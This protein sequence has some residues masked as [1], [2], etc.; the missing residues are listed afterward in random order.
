MPVPTW[1][2]WDFSGRVFYRIQ[3]YNTMV[4]YHSSPINMFGLTKDD[5]I[6]LMSDASMHYN[7]S[8]LLLDT[9]ICYEKKITWYC[10]L[11]ARTY[12]DWGRHLQN[13]IF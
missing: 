7:R 9:V 5:F 6:R 1:G 11:H 3:D 10:R 12:F 4:G 2:I 13:A 8:K